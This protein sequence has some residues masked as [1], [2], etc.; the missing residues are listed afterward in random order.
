MN[1]TESGILMSAGSSWPDGISSRDRSTLFD[2]GAAGVQLVG[3]L[4]LHERIFQPPGVLVPPAARDVIEGGADLRV[5]EGLLGHA[6]VGVFA[7]RLRVLDDR[8]VVV[9]GDI[10]LLTGPHRG[11]GATR[12]CHGQPE[13]QQSVS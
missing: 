1:L 9:A 2:V 12:H 10:G 7:H 4:N 5:V 11:A 13:E 3:Q 8:A 6:I